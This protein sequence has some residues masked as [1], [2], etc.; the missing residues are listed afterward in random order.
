MIKLIPI[1]TEIKVSNGITPEIVFNLWSNMNSILTDDSQLDKDFNNDPNIT[2]SVKKFIENSPINKLNFYYIELLKIKQ[3]NNLNEIKTQKPIPL[4]KEIVLKKYE[5][6]EG[7][8]D[9]QDDNIYDVVRSYFSP[10]D[11]NEINTF[12]KDLHHIYKRIE[13]NQV[14]WGKDVIIDI[15]ELYNDWNRW[16]KITR[17]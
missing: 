3:N 4:D 9:F 6:Q 13:H 8:Y 16:I 17:E 7:I 12:I 1:L 2:W 11:E 5:P 14:H 15:R 10:K